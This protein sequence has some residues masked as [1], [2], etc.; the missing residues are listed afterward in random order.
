MYGADVPGSLIA[1]DRKIWSRSEEPQLFTEMI[2]Q[3]VGPEKAYLY[4]GMWRATFR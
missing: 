2:E 1:A 4:F 3:L